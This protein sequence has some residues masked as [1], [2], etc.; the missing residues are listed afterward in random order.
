MK[1]GFSISNHF[2]FDRIVCRSRS[3]NDDRSGAQAHACISTKKKTIFQSSTRKHKSLTKNVRKCALRSWFQTVSMCIKQETEKNLW[4]VMRYEHRRLLLFVFWIVQKNFFFHCCC[5]VDN[6]T[7]CVG[8]SN[9]SHT[10]CGDFFPLPNLCICFACVY[11]YDVSWFMLWY[12]MDFCLFHV[13]FFFVLFILTLGVL[14]FFSIYQP[15]KLGII[16]VKHKNASFI[17]SDGP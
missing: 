13:R 14:T 5:S 11:F 6:I 7:V 12:Q 1:R 15:Q 10:S 4:G 16:I 2:S 9:M 8:F 17:L 3:V